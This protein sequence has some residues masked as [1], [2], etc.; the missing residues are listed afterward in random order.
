MKRRAVAN[1]LEGSKAPVLCRGID[2]ATKFAGFGARV[3]GSLA[4]GAG[5]EVFSTIHHTPI[6]IPIPIPKN[7]C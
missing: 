2:D 6:P 5:Y 1:K 4:K 3:I 7:Q